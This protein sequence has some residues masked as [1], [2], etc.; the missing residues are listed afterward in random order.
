MIMQ[1][2][3]K[4]I[5]FQFPEYSFILCKDKT[6][7]GNSGLLCKISR[8]RIALTIRKFCISFY[9][10]EYRNTLAEGHNLL[11]PHALK[12]RMSGQCQ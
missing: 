2:R 11:C 5:Y 9:V 12:E 4:K 7:K 10:K 6:K 3:G 1:T 8:K